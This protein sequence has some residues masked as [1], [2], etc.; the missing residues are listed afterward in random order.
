MQG[1]PITLLGLQGPSCREEL[2]QRDKP[3]V[4]SGNSK[5]S[6][7]GGEVK[8]FVPS[9]SRVVSPSSTRLFCS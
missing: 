1:S 4:E 5:H 6:S 8:T 9:P 7:R 3:V 2:L